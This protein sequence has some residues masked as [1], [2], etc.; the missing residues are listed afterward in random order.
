VIYSLKF[1]KNKF[2]KIYKK[3]IS[4][5]LYKIYINK[6]IYNYVKDNNFKKNHW[7]LTQVDS[8]LNRN[9]IIKF[10]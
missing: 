7:R 4:I 8:L 6:R 10:K 3:I 2:Y 1:S 9:P 5:V